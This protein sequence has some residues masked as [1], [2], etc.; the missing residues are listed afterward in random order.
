M[1]TSEHKLAPTKM[2]HFLAEVM[3]DLP[4]KGRVVSV[5]VEDAAYLVTLSL[6]EHG[7]RVHQLSAWDVSRSMRGDPT[8]L[9]AIRADLLRGYANGTWQGEAN[10]GA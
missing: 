3:L 6:N 8:A 1:L 9:A 2:V 7:Q 10:A 4:L 5:E